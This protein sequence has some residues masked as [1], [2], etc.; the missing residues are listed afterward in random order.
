MRK[1][2]LLSTAGLLG[3]SCFAQQ[4][5]P[6]LVR[7]DNNTGHMGKAALNAPREAASVFK[8]STSTAAKTSATQGDWFSYVDCNYIDGVAYGWY[9]SIFEDSTVTSVNSD[10]ATIY[11]SVYG[12]GMSFDPTSENYYDE[13]YQP[14]YS[15]SFRVKSKDAYSIDSFYFSGKYMRVVNTDIDTLFIE[16]VKTSANEHTFLLAF[17]SQASKDSVGYHVNPIDSVM[18]FADATYD[19]ENNKLSD[20]IDVNDI[21]RIM[22]PLDDNF[23]A[24]STAGGNHSRVIGLDNPLVVDSNEVVVA[25]VH[26]KSGGVHSLGTPLTSVNS[27]RLYTYERDGAYTYA[28][29][30]GSDYT[31]FLFATKK[32]KYGT[33]DGE[34]FFYF[35]GHKLLVPSSAYLN[36]TGFGIPDYAFYVTCQT[37]DD[38]PGPNSVNETVNNIK[39]IATPN[40]VTGNEV[41]ISFNVKNAG[42][43]VTVSIMNMMGQ[44]VQSVDM[45]NQ[46]QGAAVINTSALPA[47][48]YMYSVQANGERKTGR[49]VISH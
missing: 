3:F 12:L 26:F 30:F 8:K 46:T 10:G 47:G 37:C 25:Y 31:S 6:S 9:Y 16:L 29:Q 20:S 33:P 28:Q 42:N 13:A 27:Y 36:P 19:A 18:R 14:Q 43:G 11:H 39:A 1:L 35:Q 32:A 24:D 7:L 17:G 4:S 23:Y 2:L 38:D 5:Y 22:I 44:T 45:G 41:K 34:S 49:F 15:P 48:M 21:V 40:P